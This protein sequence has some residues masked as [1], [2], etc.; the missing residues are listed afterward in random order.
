MAERLKNKILD[1]EKAVDVIAGPDA[2]RF[3]I[4]TNKKYFKFLVLNEIVFVQNNTDTLRK[5]VNIQFSDN[6]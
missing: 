4:I 1:K 3:V 5:S 6:Y 2:Y